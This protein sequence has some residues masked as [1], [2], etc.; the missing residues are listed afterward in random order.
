MI[1][2]SLQSAPISTTNKQGQQLYPNLLKIAA[3]LD[4]INTEAALIQQAAAG[5]YGS[6][7][8]VP[9]I[10]VD[11]KK[12][13]T[14]IENVAITGVPPAGAAGGELSGTYP[15]PTVLN[16]AVIAKVL[17]GFTSGAGTITAADSILSA[18]QKLDGNITANHVLASGKI[19]RGNGSNIAVAST[20]SMA[21]TYAAGDIVYS[22]GAN[23]LT[24][25]T[26][27]AAG[28]ILIGGSAP[29]YSSSPTIST[30]VTTPL[31]IGGTAVGS[32]LELRSTSGVGTTDFVKCTVGNNG[33]T[34]VWKATNAGNLE[35]V[36]SKIIIAGT[37]GTAPTDRLE[38]RTTDGVA[39]GFSVRTIAGSYRVF[40]GNSGSVGGGQIE[41]FDNTQTQIVNISSGAESTYFNTPIGIGTGSVVSAK[42]HVKGDGNTAATFAQ[43][44][45]SSTV[46]NMFTVRDDGYIGINIIPSAAAQVNIL[47]AL[48]TGLKI[49]TGAA[50]PSTP[51]LLSGISPFLTI[52]ATDATVSGS[53]GIRANT[54]SAA[55]TNFEIY[56]I[57][58][59]TYYF[60]IRNNGNIG[61]NETTPTAR[62]HIVAT[63]EQLRLGYDDSNYHSTT[64]GSTGVTTKQ[65]IGSASATIAIGGNQVSSY[66]EIRSTGAVGTTDYIKFTVGNNGGTEAMRILNS[67]SV[68]VGT[69]TLIG[70]ESFIV[71]KNQNGLT[72][73]RF[74]N[75]TSG[76]AARAAFFVHNNLGNILA[77]QAYSS[78]YTPSGS[79]IPDSGTIEVSSL[80]TNGLSLVTGGASPIKFWTNNTERAR[81]ISGGQFGIG[82]T[83]PT[84]VVH[85]KAGTATAS[86]APLKFTSGTNL[87]TAEAGAMEYNGTNL[88]F[89]RTGTTREGVLT[90]SAVTTEVV[91]SDTTVTVNIGGTTYKLLAKA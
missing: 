16:S 81:F 34:E 84:A 31:I 19:F 8:T 15:N 26:V 35:F 27:G 79:S 2:V 29:A 5:T 82:V 4:S 7:T 74:V 90:Q 50:F 60:S 57:N 24:G 59:A 83:V 66:H 46:D 30:S 69:T 49:S 21:D 39:E 45:D 62:L 70:T 6:A 64:V 71:Q 80:A 73:M 65:S 91:V 48:E 40:I 61:I 85:L 36:S 63:S 44:I 53:W 41:L 77:F 43:R 9:K 42:I 3:D 14:S 18:I 33:A 51:L 37:A 47:T 56:D 54:R 88:F 12:N 55:Q 78:G 38:I 52:T 72:S 28:T 32:S 23:N 68:A 10:T 1:E 17:T 75:T 58:N 86:T 89:T 13:I 22:S 25:L 76:T 20:F 11:V 67:G 87:T